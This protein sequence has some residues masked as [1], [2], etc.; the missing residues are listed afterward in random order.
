LSDFR[1]VPR[2]A[3]SFPITVH[4]PGLDSFSTRHTGST[5]DISTRGLSFL[6]GFAPEPGTEFD[7]SVQLSFDLA[8]HCQAFIH[9]VARVSRVIQAGEDRFRVSASIERYYISRNSSN[10]D[11]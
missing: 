11:G 3:L 1:A 8:V 5:L 9:G 10:G 4:F 2:Y 6:L 7:F